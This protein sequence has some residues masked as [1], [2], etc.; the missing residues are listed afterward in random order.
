VISQ[1]ALDAVCA[2]TARILREERERQGV[3]MTVVAEQAGL[4]QQM[5]SYVER[6]LRKP[7]IDTLLRIAWALKIDPA[8]VLRRAQKS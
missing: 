6:G 2:N 7:N 3:S 5:V 8:D 4:S 1:K